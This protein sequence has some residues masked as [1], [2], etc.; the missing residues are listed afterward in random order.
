MKFTGVVYVLTNSF[1]QVG[2]FTGSLAVDA[3]DFFGRSVVGISVATS[4]DGK[5]IIVGAFNDE[6]GAT[7]NTGVVY[8]YDRVGNS[9]NQV[10][11]L[12]GSLA[13]DAGDSFGISVATSADGKTIIVGAD[14]D[15][16][17]A[18]ASSGVVYVYD[19]VGNSFNQVGILN[20]FSCC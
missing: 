18:N 10:G 17:G 7:T 13:V 2:I 9:F 4:A 3:G 5:T 20:W 14:F 15:E 12:T 19:R 16:I 8:V 1:N 11:I 6:I